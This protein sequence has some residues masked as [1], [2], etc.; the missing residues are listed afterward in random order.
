MKVNINHSFEVEHPNEKVWGYL[1][2]P[3]DLAD[4]VPG[5]SITE[6]VDDKTYKGTVGLKFGPV[7]ASYNADVFYE[8][9]NK[10]EK[11]I[12]LI[13]K[14]VDIR[15]AGSA[16]MKMRLQMSELNGGSKVN[17]DMEVTING[18]VAQFG[19]RLVTDASNEL[20]KQFVDNF[21]NKLNNVELS[22]KDKNIKIW[23]IIKAVLK[24][25]FSFGLKK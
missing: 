5:V 9:R 3:L 14:G 23:S 12:I 7:N 10:K 24:R 15:G 2:A 16:D 1:V 19:S 13:G 8:E 17:G 22:D 11:R 4:C 25:I 6:K 21:K 18:K 20:F